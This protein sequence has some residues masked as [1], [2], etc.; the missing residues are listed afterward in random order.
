M[1]LFLNKK[2]KVNIL[3]ARV[4]YIKLG[5]NSLK[6]RY[7]FGKNDIYYVMISV[8]SKEI[9]VYNLQNRCVKFNEYGTD[10]IHYTKIAKNMLKECGVNFYDDVRKP[11]R[12]GL[13]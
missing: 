12:K 8:Y 10:K 4:T 11:L 5:K 6:S 1:V 9:R 13:K 2:T 7:Y 3:P